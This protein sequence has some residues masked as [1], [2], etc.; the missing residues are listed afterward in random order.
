MLPLPQPVP[1]LWLGAILVPDQP[2]PE[3]VQLSGPYLCC[4][5]FFPTPRPPHS[6]NS[7]ICF[8]NSSSEQFQ[9]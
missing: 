2:E 6:S 4:D 8:G 9:A 7:N 5:Y 1:Q 3:P